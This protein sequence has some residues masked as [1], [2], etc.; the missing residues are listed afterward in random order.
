[1]S[2]QIVSMTPQQ[3]Q[4]YIDRLEEENA[5]IPLLQQEIAALK[6]ALNDNSPKRR[7]AL[8]DPGLI[9]S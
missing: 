3:V 4:E 2:K 8:L 7:A 5:Q 6:R 9:T 1:M